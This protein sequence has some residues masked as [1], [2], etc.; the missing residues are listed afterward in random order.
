MLLGICLPMLAPFTFSLLH[1][2]Q[3]VKSQQERARL[4]TELARLDQVAR[5]ETERRKKAK[6]SETLKVS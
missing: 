3:K 4:Q 6:V 1:R 5:Q 2:L